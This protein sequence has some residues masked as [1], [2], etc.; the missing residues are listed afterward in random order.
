MPRFA[1]WAGGAGLGGS[2]IASGQPCL[3]LEMRPFLGHC[4][5]AKPSPTQVSASHA[6]CPGQLLRRFPQP[7]RPSNPTFGTVCDPALCVSRWRPSCPTPP[8][9]W[10]WGSRR[11]ARGV[12]FRPTRPTARAWCGWARRPPLRWRPCRRC[13]RWG[14]PAAAARVAAEHACPPGQWWALLCRKQAVLQGECGGERGKGS[15]GLD[16]D[17]RAMSTVQRCLPGPL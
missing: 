16:R 1:L 12:A 11:R 7:L 9:R 2:D 10:T 6:D 17:G 4:P 13:S 14:A 5:R 8:R 15:A 3:A